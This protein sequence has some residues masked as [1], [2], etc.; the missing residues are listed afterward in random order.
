MHEQV[1][2]QLKFEFIIIRRIG[3]SLEMLAKLVRVFGSVIYS[4]VSSVSSSVGVDIE[5]EQRCVFFHQHTL[6]S[7]I[8][9]V[10][11]FVFIFSSVRA[12][13]CYN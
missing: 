9:Y 1:V 10:L 6:F 12:Q 3:I 5:A 7:A 8:S 2:L 11:N 4:A 13:L